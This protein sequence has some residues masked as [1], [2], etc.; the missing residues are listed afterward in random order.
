MTRK[1][2]GRC[3]H[4]AVIAIAV[5]LNGCSGGGG[6]GGDPTSGS[7][8]SGAQQD[9]TTLGV[10]GVVASGAPIPNARV[11]VYDAKGQT[12]TATANG[13]GSYSIS[14]DLT[15]MVAPFGFGAVDPSGANEDQTSIL[16]APPSG[17][18][19]TVVNI[20]PLTTAVVAGSMA[21]SSP[22]DVSNP[23]ALSG[24]M[25]SSGP[26][27]I[28]R[29][30]A[31]SAVTAANVQSAKSAVHA[32]LA[33]LFSDAGVAAGTDV[34][35]TAFKP[36]HTGLDKVLDEVTV[37]PVGAGVTI[38]NK[39]NLVGAMQVATVSQATV[40]SN[41]LGSPF[42][43]DFPSSLVAPSTFAGIVN[44]WQ[45]CFAQSPGTRVS[46]S[47]TL[48]SACQAAISTSPAYLNNGYTFVQEFSGWLSS[49]NLVNPTFIGPQVLY[50]E[51]PD[52]VLLQFGLV[53]STGNAQTTN[54]VAELING[55][56][57]ITGNQQQYDLR[58]SGVLQR[59]LIGISLSGNPT[60]N[61]TTSYLSGLVPIYRD[62]KVSNNP[63]NSQ[64]VVVTGPGLP[65]A[66]V[67]LAPNPSVTGMAYWPIAN[68]TGTAA[69]SSSITDTFFGFAQSEQS[70][71]G[72]L[73]PAPNP[74]NAVN[75]LA[76]PVTDFTQFTGYP[77]YTFVIHF[78]DASTATVVKRLLHGPVSPQNGNGFVWDE[79]SSSSM[80]LF[81]AN[82]P[83]AS[84]VSLSWTDPAFAPQAADVIFTAFN[85]TTGAQASTAL[86]P[87]ATSA[88]VNP[89][90]GTSQFP[91]LTGNGSYR[92]LEL[93][94]NNPGSVRRYNLYVY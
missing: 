44:A 31:L 30:A 56:W 49:T 18:S 41:S 39:L 82:A 55:Q 48:S 62:P 59:D 6:G 92:W 51:S 46:A 89:P 78:A 8:Q 65:T 58:I 80:A 26:Y 16:V 10:S 91:A 43:V 93:D 86:T 88:S 21:S 7:Q 72:N 45:A 35:G 14:L 77:Q 20:T 23:V 87:G 50:A 47:G 19:T 13:Q 66:G 52:K 81:T 63:A 85:G 61:P 70:D 38:T 42:T 34:V 11:T 4:S 22:Y 33:N 15:K 76:T 12:A 29:P 24:S 17:A 3:A 27:E 74:V 57:Q 75:W 94:Y 68:Q 90:P 73:S 5:I 84:S 37:V 71:T 25:V 36:D 1:F 83:A 60:A 40:A 53:D 69:T 32:L 9:P 28:S 54:L 64:Y 2:A 79:L 67:V